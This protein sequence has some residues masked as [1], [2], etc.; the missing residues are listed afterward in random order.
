MIGVFDGNSGSACSKVVAKRLFK[1]I[2]AALLPK[3][4]LKSYLTALKEKDQKLD[5]LKSFQ[6]KYFFLEDYQKVYD[7]SF[8]TYVRELVDAEPTGVDAAMMKAFERLDS[9]L[10]KEAMEDTTN[11]RLF[12]WVGMTGSGAT[13]LHL[14]GP[15]ATLATAGDS[16]VV[17]GTEDGRAKILNTEHNV[18]NAEE[19]KRVL[20][21]H[22]GEEGVVR[23]GHLL[24]AL[25]ALR[26]FG[27]FR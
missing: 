13:V 23:D 8:T 18:Q 9:D 25:T 7:E 6:D 3:K 5:I 11:G 24:G 16:M 14:S 1:Y 26:S 12:L 27:N 4:V 15:R 2:E 10:S 17:V 20:E 21:E 19:V 22:P